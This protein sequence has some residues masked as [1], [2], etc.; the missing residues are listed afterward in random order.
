MKRAGIGVLLAVLCLIPSIYAAANATND[1]ATTTL[2]VA[3]IINLTGNDAGNNLSIGALGTPQHG[4]VEDNE[5]GTVTYTPN[6][7]FHGTD[8]FN[9]TVLENA[10]YSSETEHF[11]EY[12]SAPLITWTQARDNSSLRTLYGMQGYLATVTSSAESAFISTRLEGQGWMGASDT[13]V[14][15]D[16]RWVTGPENGTAFWSGTSTGSAVGGAFTN[17]NSGEPNN[18]GDEDYGQFL[19]NGKW[20][21]LPVSNGA[22]QGYVVEY[23]GMQGDAPAIP[24]GHVT[25]TV[26]DTAAPTIAFTTVNYT[27]SPAVTLNA[28]VSDATGNVSAF[29]NDSLLF[30]FRLDSTSGIDSAGRRNL[31]S[32]GTLNRTAGRWGNATQFLGG[33]YD[34]GDFPAPGEELTIS[35]WVL[36]NTTSQ[37]ATFV[38]AWQEGS[39][40]EFSL[41]LLDSGEIGFLSGDGEGQSHEALSSGAGV[42]Q[43]SWLHIA[44]T[45][46]ST[47][48]ALYIAGTLRDSISNGSL[49]SGSASLLI[50]AQKD[51]SG[52]PAAP[53]QGSIDEVIIWNRSLGSAEIA[54]L[55]NGT[56]LSR[57][58]APGDGNHTRTLHATDDS[59]NTNASS[60][61]F[62][63][64][65]AK[66]VIVFS[67][68][69]NGTV[70]TATQ[71]ITVNFSVSDATAVT[72]NVSAILPNDTVRYPPVTGTYLANFSFPLLDGTYV[73]QVTANDSA[74]NLNASNLTLRMN[75][76][77]DDRD[78]VPDE[79]DTMLGVETSVDADGTTAFNVS[80]GG[81]ASNGTFSGVWPTA[82]T[83][84]G[85]TVVNFSFNYS[86]A[87][88]NLSQVTVRMT[89][90]GVAVTLPGVANKSIFIEDNAFIALCAKDAP[91]TDVSEIS[92][93]CTGANETDMTSCLGA[94][95]AVAYGNYTC[96]D[97]G[98][99]IMVSGLRHSGLAGT[100]AATAASESSGG[101]GGGGSIPVANITRELRE[102]G[103]AAVKIGW[104]QHVVFERDMEYRVTLHRSGGKTTVT[105]AGKSTDLADGLALGDVELSLR[106]GVALF[107]VKSTPAERI[108]E[109]VEDPVEPAGEAGAEEETPV[110][111]G[112]ETDSAEHEPG[113]IIWPW[114]LAAAIMLAFLI[115]RW[116]K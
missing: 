53:M 82:F 52:D 73:F 80:V 9:Y 3:V 19:L 5:D 25:V 23:G 100:Q 104:V 70:Y 4:T 95:S 35:A 106:D 18:V 72:V 24:T 99:T 110:I 111:S 40:Q 15:G 36:L 68:P 8:T 1:T 26:Y 6:A 31:T 57:A 75:L 47:H 56:S 61:S 93:A 64:D 32:S 55:I 54:A 17:W 74:G 115:W 60:T 96:I 102:R 107:S 78:G 49:G 34:G 2:G 41:Q 114:F 92:A 45:V 28:T 12:V 62:V 105:Y 11:Y 42:V 43:G 71:N 91:I 90:V 109:A 29:Y 116:R 50:G 97:N 79:I 76:T 63:V 94:G 7:G 13:A 67:S 88:L 101:N 103:A 108:V 30:H 83:S 89:S 113:N 20:N 48:K 27:N 14:E 39:A 51:S 21:D 86:N 59:G 87:T 33:H 22:I 44:A 69:T 37:N 85:R 16:W 84:G 65:T 66:P 77:D 112:P 98:T 46:N 81:N 10:L 38:S 58:M